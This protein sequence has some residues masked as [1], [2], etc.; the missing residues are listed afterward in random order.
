MSVTAAKGFAAVGLA[1]G[2][3]PSGDPDLALVRNLGPDFAAA[4]VFT[5]NRIKAAPVVWSQQVIKDGSLQ[6]VILNSGGANAC[7]GPDGFADTHSTA[8]RLAS[9]LGVGA[10]DIAVCSTG[11]IGHRIPVDKITSAV[12]ALV[13]RAT[14]D[15]GPLAARAIM[16]TDTVAKQSVQTRNGWTIGAMAK[17]AG[18]LAPGL[19]TML[20]VITT[21]AVVNAAD[22]DAALR[23][24][25]HV[26]FDRVDSDGAMSTNDTVLLLSSGASGVEADPGEFTEA[27]TTVCSDLARQLVADAE[28]ATHD[29]A[30]TISGAASEEDAVVVGRSIARNSLF[31]CAMFGNDPYWG[32]VLAALGTTQATFDPD[33]IDVS[34]NG[35]LMSSKGFG[36][37][38]AEVDISANREIRVD[39]DLHAGDHA[40][41]IWT[42]DLTY[43]YV[44][45]NAEYLS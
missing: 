25:T 2:I 38:D 20:V 33:A 17:G 7:T 31:K 21:D 34:F 5:S 41:T 15:G 9:E 13:A 24:A 8:E 42:N 3:K 23:A 27:L 32:R 11:V 30:I 22:L 40:A 37:P 19:A 1:A 29:I 10:I 12:P 28:G 6:A 35:V 43:D 45:E 26:T 18:M 4:A 36:V 14:E 39:V 44:K 16:T